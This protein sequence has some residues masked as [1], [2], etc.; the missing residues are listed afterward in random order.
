MGSEIRRKIYQDILPRLK[1]ER[2]TTHTN[3][4]SLRIPHHRLDTIGAQSRGRLTI[5]ENQ[6]GNPFHLVL[7]GKCL[8]QATLIVWKSQPRHWT[9]IAVEAL[10]VFVRGQKHHFKS[11]ARSL[12]TFVN[13]RELGS[14]PLAWTTPEQFDCENTSPATAFF[15]AN[16]R[17][18]YQWALK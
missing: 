4:D 5:D 3:L 16:L 1:K 17:N 6:G 14:E 13:L 2:M 10:L 9:E 12:E 11:F 8:F 7:F 15:P 18:A